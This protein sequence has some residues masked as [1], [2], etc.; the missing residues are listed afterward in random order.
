MSTWAQ[1]AFAVLLGISVLVLSIL[2]GIAMIDR[3]GQAQTCE[4]S[5]KTWTEHYDSTSP[6][7]AG[8]IDNRVCK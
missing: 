4:R 8:W 7:Y 3:N 6:V 5:G 2:G 1:N